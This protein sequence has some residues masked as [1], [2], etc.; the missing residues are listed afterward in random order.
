MDEGTEPQRVVSLVQD[1]TV[2][3]RAQ[4]FGHSAV[5]LSHGLLIAGMAC[6]NSIYGCMFGL[7]TYRLV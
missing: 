5:L 2:W 7:A 6:H 1:H 3:L 4:V